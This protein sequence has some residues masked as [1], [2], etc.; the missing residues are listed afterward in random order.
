MSI[1][2]ADSLMGIFGFKRVNSAKR[3]KL[4][5]LQDK[6]DKAMSVYI[7]MKYADC[8]GNVKCVSCGKVVPWKESDCGHFIPKSRGAAV[9]W[10]E[11]NCHPECHGC[12]RFSH[13]HLI[14]YTLYMVD[15][16]GREKIEELEQMARKVLSASEKR[17][18]A[19]E[20]FEYY[21][22]ALNDL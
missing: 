11:E 20:A 17:R 14:G 18:L 5:T 3:Q 16:Y 8:D 9:R 21:K 19:E 6:A 22:R 13:S 7:R 10:I 2:A 1:A 12:N 4:S 15:M